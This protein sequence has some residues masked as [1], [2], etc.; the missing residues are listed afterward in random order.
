M[1]TLGFVVLWVMI[2]LAVAM[3]LW[4]NLPVPENA[5]AITT[6]SWRYRAVRASIPSI[7]CDNRTLRIFPAVS[8][9]GRQELQ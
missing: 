1:R 9:V 6:G 8:G 3:P 5:L 7:R 2:G 4:F